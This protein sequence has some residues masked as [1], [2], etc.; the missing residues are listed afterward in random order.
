M[1]HGQDQIEGDRMQRTRTN[2]VCGVAAMALLLILAVASSA[3][4]AV[5]PGHYRLT[6]T[7]GSGNELEITIGADGRT[8]ENTN[9]FVYDESGNPYCGWGG[10]LRGAP[11]DEEPPA[12]IS[13]DGSFRWHAYDAD[14]DDDADTIGRFTSATTVEAD[15]TISGCVDLSPFA[16]KLPPMI[17]VHFTGGLVSGSGPPPPSGSLPLIDPQPPVPPGSKPRPGHGYPASPVPRPGCVKEAKAGELVGV[18]RCWRVRGDVYSTGDRARI[19]GLD[20]TP[21]VPGALIRLDRRT[22]SI[23]STGAVEVRIGPLLLWRGRIEWR[24]HEQV[25]DAKSGALLGL[26]VKGGVQL[27]LKGGRTK[28]TVSVGV[29]DDPLIKRLIPPGCL[30]LPLRRQG[31]G[32]RVPSRDLRH[33]R[34]VRHR[35]GRRIPQGR[36]I[37]RAAQ[38]AT[39]GGDLPPKGRAH[40]AVQPVRMDR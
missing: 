35:R 13:D 15:V 2:R 39:V 18:A 4:A 8:V 32:V 16:P 1:P 12:P 20:F 17:T 3:S 14:F 27:T 40:L 33:R 9:S 25:F 11:I 24:S 37:R 23:S 6:S 28:L 36:R 34:R 38:Q 26:P 31:D 10:A 7:Q 22:Q 19:N 29:P 21:A 5:V 30:R